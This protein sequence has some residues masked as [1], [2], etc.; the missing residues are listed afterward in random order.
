MSKGK[1]NSSLSANNAP[2]ACQSAFQ[3]EASALES[4]VQMQANQ[5]RTIADSIDAT[6]MRAILEAADFLDVSADFS[7]SLAP[8]AWSWVNRPDLEIGPSPSETTTTADRLLD[9]ETTA[10]MAE[11]CTLA[12][13]A[14]RAEFMKR[15]LQLLYESDF[16]FGFATP[17][18]EFVQKALHNYGPLAREWI[19]RLYN[20]NFGE[21]RVM[22]AILRIIAHFEYDE[23]YPQGMTMAAAALLH[24]DSSVRECAIRCFE[25][26]EDPSNLEILRNICVS[27]GWL[28]DYL[29]SVI[30]D[31]EGLPAHAV[32]R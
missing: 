11:V 30:S 2:S 1:R 21:P 27:D 32:S 13:G 17:A 20:A 26:W 3:Q 23:M 10:Q 12:E 6:N 31:L 14:P 16:E 24:A 22:C 9:S 29:D 5:W 28:R 25:N 8:I 7:R 18:D 15:L 19:N 4:S